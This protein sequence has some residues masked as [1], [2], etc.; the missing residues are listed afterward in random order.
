MREGQKEFSFIKKIRF[1]I[2]FNQILKMN[3]LILI[4]TVI[5]FDYEKK[6]DKMI[7]DITVD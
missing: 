3:F 5:S 4:T 6:L 1:L 7:S 2:K